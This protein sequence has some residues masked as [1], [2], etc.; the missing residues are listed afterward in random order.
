MAD[1]TSTGDGRRSET[2]LEGD[3]KVVRGRCGPTESVN[4]P[5]KGAE[6]GGHGP[7]RSMSR[8]RGLGPGR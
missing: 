6:T 1:P 7:Y 3:D 8:H 4:H 5:V 2:C